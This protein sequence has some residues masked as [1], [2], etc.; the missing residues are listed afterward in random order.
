ME[1][2]VGWDGSRLNGDWSDLSE[3]AS[4]RFMRINPARPSS[5]ISNND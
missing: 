1:R 3:K 4:D 2:M 5:T